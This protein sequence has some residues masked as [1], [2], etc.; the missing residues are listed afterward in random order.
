MICALD[1]IHTM[2]AG[3]VDRGWL[4]HGLVVTLQ[5]SYSLYG[6]TL[7]EFTCDMGIAD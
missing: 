1:K 5:I 2:H 4:L 3:R 7:W 6:G